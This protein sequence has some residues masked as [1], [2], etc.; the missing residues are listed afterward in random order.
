MFFFFFFFLLIWTASLLE[1]TNKLLLSSSLPPP[2]LELLGKPTESFYG[3]ARKRGSA[4]KSVVVSLGRS[5]LV[6]LSLSLSS[7]FS[8]INPFSLFSLSLPFFPLSRYTISLRYFI[9]TFALRNGTT[10]ENFKWKIIVSTFPLRFHYLFPPHRAT[11]HGR[12][13]TGEFTRPCT[14]LC[15]YIRVYTHRYI[16]VC[17]FRTYESITIKIYVRFCRRYLRCIRVTRIHVPISIFYRFHRFTRSWQI[18]NPTPNFFNLRLD[19]RDRV[20]H[21]LNLTLPINSSSL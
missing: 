10:V 5:P 18:V 9:D 7:S 15:I 13:T 16:Y 19:T 14:Y 12:E 21:A 6:S 2:P 17:S 4:F 8:P 3:I 11:L 20:F 1:S